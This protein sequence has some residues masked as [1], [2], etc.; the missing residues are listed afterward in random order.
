MAWSSHRHYRVPRFKPSTFSQ[1]NAIFQAETVYEVIVCCSH[2]KKSRQSLP[3]LERQSQPCSRDTKH[4]RS[5]S[6]RK[7][8]PSESGDRGRS[9]I[10]R[11]AV[12]RVRVERTMLA[13]I[14]S[15]KHPRSSLPQ[16][17]CHSLCISLDLQ[18]MVFRRTPKHEREA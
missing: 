10:S 8:L 13:T 11:L 5:S 3:Q 9:R 18:E 4:M 7:R 2:S 14:N 12:R 1:E 15:P 6:T 16:F 17:V